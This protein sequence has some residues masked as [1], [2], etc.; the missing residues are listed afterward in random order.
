MI[1][2]ST[3]TLSLKSQLKNAS[4]SSMAAI[5]VSGLLSKTHDET[6]RDFFESKRRGGPIVSFIRNGNVAKITFKEA[7]GM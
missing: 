3:L 6:V 4:N 7:S 2:N 5:V 1:D